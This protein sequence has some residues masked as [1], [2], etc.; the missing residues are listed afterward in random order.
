[1][2]ANLSGVFR[3]IRVAVYRVRLDGDGR[4]VDPRV[5]RVIVLAIGMYPSIK[6]AQGAKKARHEAL[7]EA[8]HR[9]LYG[10]CVYGLP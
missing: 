9:K 10:W 1:M 6:A 4:V 8:I 7:R 2:G 5:C 3:L